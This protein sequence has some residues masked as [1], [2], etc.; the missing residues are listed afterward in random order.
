[1]DVLGAIAASLQLAQACYQVQQRL[2]Q[3]PQDQ[4]L[5]Q[6]IKKECE[7][8]RITVD[9][10]Q[11]DLTPEGYQASI[12][13]RESINEILVSIQKYERR[14]GIAKLAARLELLGPSF[15]Q[16]LEIVLL[17]YQS[18][19]TIAT[20]AA[21]KTIRNRVGPQ[22]IT[23]EVEEMIQ[24]VQSGIADLASQN[25]ELAAVLKINQETASAI[26]DQL[27]AVIVMSP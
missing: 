4:R 21:I 10:R 12:H 19:V 6:F 23:A 20:D 9:S 2:R 22:G 8:I 5:I 13:L 18:I 1:M 3:I 15:K 17:E 27:S 16:R 11:N 24:P 25:C 26:A 7:A 14:T